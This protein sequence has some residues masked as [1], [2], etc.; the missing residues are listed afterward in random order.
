VTRPRSAVALSILALA[1]AWGGAA[2]AQTGGAGDAAAADESTVGEVI[3]TGSR[4]ARNGYDTPTPVT[5]IGEGEIE[6]AAPANIADFVNDLPSVSGSSTRQTGNAAISSGAA[7]INS[8]NLRALGSSRTLVLLDGRRTVGSTVDG[9]ADVNTF[10]QGLVKSIEIVTGGASAAYGSDAVSGVVNFILDKKY[11][12]FKAT[13]EAGQTTYEDDKRW[14]A[15][16]SAGV[17]F[18][19]G[20]GHLLLNGEIVDSDGIY[21]VPRSWNDKG[22]YIVQNPAF[23]AGNGQPDYLVTRNAGPQLMTPGG[24]IVSTSSAAAT[25]ALRG[26]YFGA[27]GAVSRL[28]YGV[29]RNANDPDM[30]GGDWQ[31]TRV[32]NTQSLLADE[33]RKGIFGRLSF[34]I[35]DNITMFGEGSWNR[36][37]SVGW[38]GAQRNEGGV[39]LRIDNAF[40]PA[41]VRATAIANGVNATSGTIT[42]GTSNKDLDASVGNRVTDNWREVQRYV[43]GFEGS[44]DALTLP[45]KWDASIQQGITHT[46]EEV[47]TTN[48]ARLALGQDAVFAPAGNALGV[49]AGTIVCRSSLTAP[50][51]GCVPFNRLGV[52]VNSAAAINYV[53]GFPYREQR[54]QQDVAVLNVSTNI[55]NPWIA[56]IGLAFGIEHRKEK[57]S[58]FVPT[59][60]QAGWFTGNY[61]PTSGAYKVTEGYAEALV[62]PFKGFDLNGAVRLT[63][64]STSGRVTTW[65]IGATWQPLPDV[66]LRLTRSRDIRAPN[67]AELFQAG[68]RR[69]NTV[70]D[71]FAG[72]IPVQF[73][74]NTTGNRNLTP[75]RADSLGLGVVFRPTFL[76][77][78]G[79]SVDYYKIRIEDAIGTVS[80]DQIVNSCFA[81]NQNF[82]TA[83]TRQ[84]NAQGVV[85]ITD[86]ANS[87]FNFAEVNTEGLDFEVSYRMGLD[88]I[89]SSLRGD[90]MLRAIATHYMK[91]VSDNGFDPPV[92]RA[93]QNAGG[94]P[95]WLYRLTATYTLDAFTAQL[96]GRGISSGTYSNA[97]IECA[98]ACPASTALAR[99][100]NDNHIDG[101]F[102]VDAYLSYKLE[103]G[104]YRGE[105][106]FNVQ[107]LFNEDPAIVAQGPSGPGH[108]NPTT[109]SG[110]YDSIGRVF[111]VG[112]RFSL[113]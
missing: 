81:G 78:F 83:L 33:R 92:D 14:K 77:G 72:N 19:G 4:V 110:V 70:I 48:N 6:Q 101:A 52:G 79:A 36:D 18:A 7:G 45:W 109:D 87:P 41:A 35:A 86:V 34:D 12:G 27:G 3:V 68:Q 108:I 65:K 62:T 61:L 32:N 98:S 93:G 94:T 85:V 64:Y 55:E 84:P 15:T 71:P 26:T 74:E 38:G 73:L 54:F 100:I 11:E 59:D 97:Y 76:P 69:T 96:T 90:L 42:I 46:H 105:V 56:P 107:N 103:R 30:I 53:M 37:A 22:W 8:I 112:L 47:G 10:P 60:F 82:C 75:E 40:I 2:F 44:L 24:I 67:L 95:E 88:D 80:V 9:T 25:T 5:V 1:S 113:Q 66:K 51:N 58:G 39:T 91:L 89:S 23:A 13:V 29:S 63:D 50:T 49:P 17:A 106:Y 102:Y 20:K 99:T 43:F 104:P 21:G 31:L 28:N 111:R 16:A 57:V